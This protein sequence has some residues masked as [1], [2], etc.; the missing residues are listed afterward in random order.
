[1]TEAGNA[2]ILFSWLRLATGNRYDPVIRAT[3]RFL[4]EQR[5][6][7]FVAPCSRRWRRRGQW[8]RSIAERIYA[9]ARSTCLSVTQ[10]TG[11]RTMGR[12]GAEAGD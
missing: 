10:G 9:R 1:L 2:E 6:R 3:E 8:G 5:R 4:T 11:D 12:S 7:K